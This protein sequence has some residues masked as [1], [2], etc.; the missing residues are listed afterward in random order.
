M[1][2]QNHKVFDEHLPWIEGGVAIPHLFVGQGKYHIKGPP[3]KH[4]AV[5]R[6]KN[7]KVQKFLMIIFLEKKREWQ[8]PQLFID[9]GG[10]PKTQR[11]SKNLRTQKFKK[12]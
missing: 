12:I 4:T 6:N 9:Q 1:P 11:G 3:Q 10:S 2:R 5:A 7:W 8:L